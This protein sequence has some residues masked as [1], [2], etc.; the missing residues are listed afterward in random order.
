[1]TYLRSNNSTFNYS[2]FDHGFSLNS[3]G[4]FQQP[5]VLVMVCA[6]VENIARLCFATVEMRDTV[7][8]QSDYPSLEGIG[9]TINNSKF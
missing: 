6:A 5:S 1:M 9:G 8:H 2:E 7:N 4:S 3:A